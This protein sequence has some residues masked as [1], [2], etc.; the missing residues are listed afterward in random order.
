M[1]DVNLTGSFL[2]F[3]EGLRAMHGKPWG[4]VIAI[5]STARLRRYPEVVITIRGKKHWLWR[6]SDTNGDVLDILVQTRRNARA[7]KRFSQRL[8]AQFGEPKVVITDNLR[9]YLKPIKTLAPDADHRA[10]KGL[11]NAIKVSHRPT[12][13][14]ATIANAH[15]NTG[16]PW[17][18]RHNNWTQ[19]LAHSV[20]VPMLDPPQTKSV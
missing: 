11:N 18:V 2:T 3:R 7:A 19:F 5:A 12:R 16:L 15:N 1:V 9:S 17:Q 4:R 13:K 8:I 6:A 14:L 10:Y 20:S